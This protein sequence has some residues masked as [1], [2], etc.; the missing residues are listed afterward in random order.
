MNTQELNI[1]ERA[2]RIGI[3]AVLII[4]T[5]LVPATP[6]GW[7]A[8][9]PL[10]GTLPIFAGLFGYDPVSRFVSRELS[11]FV[12]EIRHYHSGGHKPHHG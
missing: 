8:V 12:H 4:F 11:H 7:L 5:M 2:N 6:L 3:G 9:L 1:H 10:I